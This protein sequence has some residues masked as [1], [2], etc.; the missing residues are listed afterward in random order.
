MLLR[1]QTCKSRINL[2]LKISKLAD[3]AIGQTA[4]KRKGPDED[5]ND[6]SGM[7]RHLGI[8]REDHGPEAVDR[9]ASQSKY[10]HR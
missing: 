7:L 4:N 3:H 8:L 1:K 6:A 10:R 2:V 9:A 5:D